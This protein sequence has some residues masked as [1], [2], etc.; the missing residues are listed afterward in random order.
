MSNLSSRLIQILLWV[1]MG[2]TVIM[3]VIFYGGAVTEES[4]GTNLEEPVITET[5][6][7][8]AYIL[9]GLTAGITLAFSVAG[10]LLNPRGAKKTLIGVAVGAVVIFIAWYLADDTVLNLPH[11]TGSDNVPKTLKIVDTGLFTTYLLAG[12]AILA[13]IYS[14]ISKAFK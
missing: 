5:F 13:I 4:I 14:E 10:M 2:V 12:L 9:L 7:Y 11:Y 3:A 8:W 6:I 1:L